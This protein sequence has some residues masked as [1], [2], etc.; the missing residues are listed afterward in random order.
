[1][2]MW[3]RWAVVAVMGV[4]ACVAVGLA[5][6]SFRV[7]QVSPESQPSVKQLL[8][9]KAE[10]ARPVFRVDG[11]DGRASSRKMA[12]AVAV[13]GL[14]DMD[15]E[16]LIDLLGGRKN[17]P[18]KQASKR[19]GEIG[20]TAVPALIARLESTFTNDKSFNKLRWWC[21]NTLG[22]IR[23][24]RATPILVKCVSLDPDPHT[25][26]RSI[27]ALNVIKDDR[28]I[29]MLRDR[30]KATESK[31]E[32]FNIATA[33]SSMGEDD[34]IRIIE[35]TTRSEDRWLRWQAVSALGRI[36]SP[37]T[38]A[39]LIKCLNDPDHSIRQEV[40]MSL[41]RLEDK[42]AAPALI[43][44]LSDPKPGVRWRAARALGQLKAEEAIPNLIKLLDD[45]DASVMSQAAV[46]LGQLGCKSREV[47]KKTLK[48]LS[49]PDKDVRSKAASA[50]AN[51]GTS[52]DIEAVKNA[53][54]K[55]GK[56]HIRRKLER[57]IKALNAAGAR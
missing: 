16:Q 38:L 34:G 35:E 42:A 57:S 7:E 46:A 5:T 19:L 25:R 29:D 31:L 22:N 55:E 14:A 8:P 10:T 21:V 6:Y 44:A 45:K 26:W 48:M 56:K 9:E 17:E 27:W 24:K 41:G 4:G 54:E 11:P 3:K 23:D 1:M 30:M 32:Q 49:S 51:I 20:V 2:V 47:A 36:K 53:L 13:P 43:E 37:E 33:L 28:R 50:I 40:A 18:T 15:V 39:I 52:D 12:T